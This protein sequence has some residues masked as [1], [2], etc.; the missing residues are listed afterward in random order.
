MKPVP[1]AWENTSPPLPTTTYCPATRFRGLANWIPGRAKETWLRPGWSHLPK[2]SPGCASP[3]LPCM[4]LSTTSPVVPRRQLRTS[5]IATDLTTI[6]LQVLPGCTETD[7]RECYCSQ[8]PSFACTWITTGSR[9]SPLCPSLQYLVES[10][11][12][13][14]RYL[15]GCGLKNTEHYFCAPP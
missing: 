9:L 13:L 15:Y 5:C 14:L 12:I 1:A 10:F 2:N 3:S 6:C 7:A 11:P 4:W 8:F